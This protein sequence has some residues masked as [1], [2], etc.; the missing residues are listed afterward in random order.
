MVR[1]GADVRLQAVVLL[2]AVTEYGH[3]VA[4]GLGIILPDGVLGGR[5]GP[6]ARVRLQ[7]PSLLW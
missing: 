5:S 7:A 2:L 4:G 3:M 1:G 6:G